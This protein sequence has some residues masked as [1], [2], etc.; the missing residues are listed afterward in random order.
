MIFYP[1]LFALTSSALENSSTSSVAAPQIVQDG[2]R[3]TIGRRTYGESSKKRGKGRDEER[4]ERGRE[5]KREGGRKRERGERGSE[6][7][8]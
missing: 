1:W 6:R 4:G 2:F 3:G 5:G 8:T 7:E